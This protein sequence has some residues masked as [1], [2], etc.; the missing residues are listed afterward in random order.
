M[1]EDFAI[2]ICFTNQRP[3]KM[4]L[5]VVHAI[6]LRILTDRC[7]CVGEIIMALVDGTL[8]RRSKTSWP[9]LAEVDRWEF[10]EDVTVGCG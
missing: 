5:G 10:R 2:T 7:H 4:F 1:I 3:A 9:Y 6:R 8:V